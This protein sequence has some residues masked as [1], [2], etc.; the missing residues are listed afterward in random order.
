MLGLLALAAAFFSYLWAYCLTD[1][2]V[3]ADMMPP[4]T[5]EADPRPKW[6]VSTWFVLMVVFMFAGYLLQLVSRRELNSI[7][8]M[9][10]AE[11]VP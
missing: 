11:E 5:L 9:E 2:L 3:A 4:V 8:E 6:F 1:A 7:A 10:K